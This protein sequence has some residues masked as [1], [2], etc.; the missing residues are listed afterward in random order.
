MRLR[1]RLSHGGSVDDDPQSL[2][3]VHTPNILII[4]SNFLIC[5]SDDK[6]LVH[7]LIRISAA[8]QLTYV[9]IAPR[10]YVFTPVHGGILGSNQQPTLLCHCTSSIPHHPLPSSAGCTGPRERTNPDAP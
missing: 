3:F 5:R 7:P 2:L 10:P 6:D 1:L 9:A 8:L 4:G